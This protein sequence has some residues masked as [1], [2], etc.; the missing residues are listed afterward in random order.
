MVIQ[1]WQS[2]L[3]F[4]SALCM[5]IFCVAPFAL[6][7]DSASPDSLS[8]I[9]PSEFTVYLI[10]NMTVALLL[11]VTIFLYK[12]LRFQRR[13]TLIAIMLM[14]V[15]AVT[16]ILLIYVSLDNAALLL[17]GGG[18][19]ILAAIVTAIMAYRCMGRDYR[20]LSSMDRIR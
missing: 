2:V 16:G 19:L 20:L 8:V 17:F 18:L 10:F 3:L 5:A 4:I 6:I 14:V 13:V 15:S 11:F 7:N 12:N 1:R 9:S